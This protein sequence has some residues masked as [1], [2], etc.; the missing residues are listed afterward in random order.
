MQRPGKVSNPLLPNVLTQLYNF[1]R[2]EMPLSREELVM[3]YQIDVYIR[4]MVRRGNLPPNYSNTIPERVSQIA[5]RV[6]YEWEDN[7]LYQQEQDEIG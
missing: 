4:D 5:A 3:L 2:P 7:V 6:F 1:D